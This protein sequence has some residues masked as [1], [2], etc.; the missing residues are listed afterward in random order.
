VTLQHGLVE[1]HDTALACGG[2][3]FV[4]ML[5]IG[6]LIHEWKEKTNP[7]RIPDM[8]KD[9]FVLLGLKERDAMDL[10]LPKRPAVEFV[11]QT[12]HMSPQLVI[13]AREKLSDLLLC[14]RRREIDIPGRQ[15]GKGRGVA[16][17]QAMQKRGST[18]Q[19]PDDEERLFNGLC[20]VSGEKDVVQKETEPVHE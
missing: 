16:R 8:Q 20:F 10:E 18:S 6:H 17:E 3:G 13:E 14:D 2:E 12:V 7:E 15:A 5:V 9:I 4:E 11:Q 1:R 19:V